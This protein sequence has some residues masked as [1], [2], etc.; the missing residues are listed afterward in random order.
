MIKEGEF[1][2]PACTKF[3]LLFNPKSEE[4][5]RRFHACWPLGTSLD[6]RQGW[7]KSAD[8]NVII[9]SDKLEETE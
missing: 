9:I 4:E 6:E 1:Q 8:Y 2:L 7:N 5:R 3:D